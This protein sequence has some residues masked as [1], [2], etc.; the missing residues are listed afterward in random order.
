MTESLF[1]VVRGDQG[2]WIG[3]YGPDGRLIAEGHS[4]ESSELLRL[5]GV[6]H[7]NIYDVAI[8]DDEG[9]LPPTLGEVAAWG[10]TTQEVAGGLS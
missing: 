1:A 9:H 3:L 2:D 10:G 7:L 6:P 4:F 5:V 8:P